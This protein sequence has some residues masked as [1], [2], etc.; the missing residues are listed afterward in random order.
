M[1]IIFDKNLNYDINAVSKNGLYR[2][3]VGAI[4]EKNGLIF[5]ATRIDNQNED[6]KTLQMP[7][8]GVDDGEELY[9]AVLRE[10]YEETGIKSDKLEFKSRLE[11]WLYYEIPKDYRPKIQNRIGQVHIW[12]NFKF[13]GCDE[14]INLNA[15]KHNEFSKFFW[16]KSYTIIEKSIH[17]KQNLHLQIFKNFSL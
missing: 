6:E 17:F 7:Q 12:F 11:N 10:I 13:L 15:T 3:G 8:G 9:T 2:I 1:P 5:C 4:I 14:D 16:E